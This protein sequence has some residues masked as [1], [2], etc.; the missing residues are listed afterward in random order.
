MRFK[1]RK[2][3][4]KGDICDG[5]MVRA[6]EKEDVEFLHCKR[7]VSPYISWVLLMAFAV[8]LSALM[9]SFMVDYTN[10]SVSDIK[11][12]VYNA[13]ECRSVSLV[14]SSSCFS[15]QILNITLE[16][17][18]YARI[19]TM[20]FRLFNGRVPIHMN[21][22]NISMNPNRVKAIELKTGASA[23]T[24]VEVIPHIMKEDMDIV[25]TDRKVQ[26]DVLACS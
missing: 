17:N 4:T 21:Q 23:V 25:C 3:L 15:A 24:M 7:A 1:G 18:N 22:T 12:V 6:N 11:R 19:D 8:V 5:M 13:D 14:I 9:Y 20:D 2:R 26:A 16:N 10:D